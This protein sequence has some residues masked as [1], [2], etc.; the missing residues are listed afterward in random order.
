MTFIN[1]HPESL[2]LQEAFD[3][4]GGLGTILFVPRNISGTHQPFTGSSPKVYS[5]GIYLSLR[6]C[7][8]S[9]WTFVMPNFYCS[10]TGS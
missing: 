7:P 10:E 6:V 3:P 8:E 5:C 4:D 9:C 1:E 2:S